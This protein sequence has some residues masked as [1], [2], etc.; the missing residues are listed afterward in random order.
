MALSIVMVGCCCWREVKKSLVISACVFGSSPVSCLAVTMVG[1]CSIGVQLNI[2]LFTIVFYG[3]Y[4][5]FYVVF[6]CLNS[7]RFSI[8]LSNTLSSKKIKLSFCSISLIVIFTYGKDSWSVPH[9][10]SIK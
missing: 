7:I 2:R 6:C 5:F 4:F 1:V 10:K 9:P 8:L 3:Y